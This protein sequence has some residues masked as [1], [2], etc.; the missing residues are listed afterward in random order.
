MY[1]SCP[2]D[3]PA[4]E[5]KAAKESTARIRSFL[6][7]GPFYIPSAVPVR[8]DACKV[9]E[10]LPADHLDHR[11]ADGLEQCRIQWSS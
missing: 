4:V 1:A 7:L 6:H 3:A 9:D 8:G 2:A 10:C 5:S 11:L